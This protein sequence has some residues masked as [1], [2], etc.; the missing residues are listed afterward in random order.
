MDDTVIFAHPITKRFLKDIQTLYL[1]I[2]PPTQPGDLHVVLKAL[3]H[4]PFAPLATCSLL[5]LSMK[6]AFLMAI[7]SMGQLGALMAEPLYTIFLKDKVML[8]TH[9]KF[10]PTVHSSFHLNEPIHL[11]TFFPKLHVNPF[12]AA[13][14]TLDV[15]RVLSFYLDRSKLLRASPKL[16]I[17]ISEHTKGKSI[18]TQRISNWIS[19]YIR[20]CYQLKH[21][22]PPTSVKA[23]STR[24]VSSSIAFLH[25]IP[26]ADIRT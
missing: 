3:M 9:P 15:C 8:W 26:L 23:H 16:F 2:R 5:D 6:A 25:N 18:S 1:D 20:L 10:L 22:Q 21:I 14:H 13:V 11:P 19:D 7:T 24:S 12:E 4:K 17:S